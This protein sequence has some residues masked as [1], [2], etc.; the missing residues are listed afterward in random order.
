M[1]FTQLSGFSKI[2]SK[3]ARNTLLMP[4]V[5]T[6]ASRILEGAARELFVSNSF[7][8]KTV[9]LYKR[10]TNG[11][12]CSCTNKEITVEK[13]QDKSLFLSDFVLKFDGKLNKTLDECP[14]CFGVGLV[15]GY[16]R[17]GCI[18]LVLDSTSPNSS[19]IDKTLNPPYFFKA[20][21]KMNTVT[22]KIEI[23]KYFT[24]V[25][26]IA[27]EWKEEPAEWSFTV[28]GKPYRNSYLECKQGQFANK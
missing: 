21:N 10:L 28:D 22:W 26:S 12:A 3:Q 7:Y 27:I 20:N 1:I 2:S 6:R 5:R 19:S 17:V 4:E 9:E 23:P 25:V 16:S 14:I 13:T 11:R 8:P 15:G 24:H 18:S